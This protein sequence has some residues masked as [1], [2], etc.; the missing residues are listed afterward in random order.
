MCNLLIMEKLDYC[1]IHDVI[2]SATIP[3]Y[4]TFSL[5]LLHLLSDIEVIW[6]KTIKHAL[7]MFYTLIIHGLLTNQS[8]CRVLERFSIERQK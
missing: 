6:P 4:A 7:S 5:R 2:K 8:V 1:F 3:N